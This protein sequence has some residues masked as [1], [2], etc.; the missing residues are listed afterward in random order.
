M[1]KFAFTMIELVFVIVIIGI[2]SAMIIPRLD[3]DNRF[4]AA[5]QVLNHIKYTQHL[6]L[7]EDM[8]QDGNPDTGP[9][10]GWFKS[11][12]EIQFYTCGGYAIHSDRGQNGGNA[13][14]LD[15]ALDPQTGK[16]LWIGAGVGAN[17]TAPVAGDF[18]KMDLSE[19]Y[20]LVNFTLTPSCR[21]AVATTGQ[22]SFDSL[23]RPYG[24]N[25]IDGV[26]KQ[27]CNITLSFNTGANEVVSIHAE[28]GYACILNTA[29]TN[30]L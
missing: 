23:G 22:I 8:F 12:W 24:A 7:T 16:R 25:I 11:R 14:S 17:C 6:A 2:M 21:G 3:R 19:H 9:G 13:A 1:R 26:I 29:G 20:D 27:D 10:T 15:A 18:E 28:T 30:C 4:E 5:T